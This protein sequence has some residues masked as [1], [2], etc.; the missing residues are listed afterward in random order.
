MQVEISGYLPECRSATLAGPGNRFDRIGN[1][2]I[3]PELLHII[4]APTSRATNDTRVIGATRRH[5]RTGH[6]LGAARFIHKLEQL[7]GKPVA[8]KRPGPRPSSPY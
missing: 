2:Q 1:C 7:T 8:A 3:G 5:P 4:G 6:P